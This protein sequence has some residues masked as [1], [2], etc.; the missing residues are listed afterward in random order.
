MSLTL[1]TLTTARGARR[2]RRR[3]GRGN[4]SRGNYSGRGAKGQRSRTGGHRGIIRRSL[5]S[6][7]ERVPKRRGFRSIHSKPAIVDVQTIERMLKPDQPVT[8]QRMIAAGLVQRTATAVKVLGR[9]KLS[10]PYR[11]YADAFSAAAKQA[12][13]AAGGSAHLTASPG[14]QPT[15]KQST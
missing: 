8:L 14:P 1:H 15:T 6:L 7:L 10:K 2:R 4:A 5:R 9:S 13:E 12:I 3:V 11:V